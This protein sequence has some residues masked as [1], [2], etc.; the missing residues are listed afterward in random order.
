MRKIVGWR[1]IVVRG[2]CVAG[3]GVHP[4]A[5]LGVMKLLLP[6]AFDC[7]IVP[8][9][10]VVRALLAMLLSAAERTT[11]IATLGVA[12]I[13]QKANPAVATAHDAT[14][15]IRIASVSQGRV[16]CDLI[17]TN[18]RTGA[19]VLVPIPRKGENL[20]DG[21][22]KKARLSVTMR[23][24]CCMSSPYPLDAP[25]SRGGARIFYAFA[26]KPGRATRANHPGRIG[27]RTRFSCP[28]H[29]TSLRPLFGKDYLEKK[30]RHTVKPNQEE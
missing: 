10:P 30:K 2:R 21:Y 8:G 4:K 6:S 27:H 5:A 1:K 28:D 25:S 22:G 24:C 12:G 3:G 9:A 18:K 16:E 23:S 13:G 17:L 11:Q 14:P 19:I 15:Q 26:P 20:L 29:R 7:P